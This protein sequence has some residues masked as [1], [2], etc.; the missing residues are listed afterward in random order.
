MRLHGSHLV[1]RA[2]DTS[3]IEALTDGVF[4]IVMTLMVFEIRLPREETVP[5]A[6]ALAGMWPEFF[7]YAVSFVQLG[8]YWVG[9]R[10]QYAF[11]VREDHVLRWSNLLFLAL[12]SLIPFT[13]QLIAHHLAS[14]LALGLYAANLILVGLV[15]AW[16][17]RYATHG[18]RLVAADLAPA[19]VST[20]LR[21]T[22]TAPL[23]YAL[24]L[25]LAVV[26]PVLTL[27]LFGLVPVFY[28]VPTLIDRVWFVRP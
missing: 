9:H 25:S 8:I 22:V 5:L 12:V 23:M 27:G 4:A 19:V 6:R 11:I 3:R 7:A 10:S 17:W 2:R 14:P 21:R 28:L 1:G 18:R 26:S 24:A 13:T 20:G 16:H 15:L